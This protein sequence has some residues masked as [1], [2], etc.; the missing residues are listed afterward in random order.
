MRAENLEEAVEH[1]H[2]VFE[3]EGVGRV[4]SEGKEENE[5]D[6]R[7]GGE[8]EGLWERQDFSWIQRGSLLFDWDELAVEE[9]ESGE[10]GARN[11]RA[12]AQSE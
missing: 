3:G 10:Q 2:W 1:D 9:R 7:V 6:K 12:A 4:D 8:V 11:M 5:D